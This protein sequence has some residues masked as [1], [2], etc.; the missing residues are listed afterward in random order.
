ME[1]QPLQSTE[2]I[3]ARSE[4]D[5]P[6]SGL[7]HRTQPVLTGK[8][9]ALLE[10]FEKHPNEVLPRALLLQEVWGT[11]YTGGPRTVD[12]HV[13]RLRAKLR[14]RVALITLRGRGYQLLSSSP[15]WSDTEAASAG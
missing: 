13:C 9:K 12:V 2:E 4:W 1:G 5:S 8:E 3:L 11:V 7:L 15:L 10:Y 14:D 6:D